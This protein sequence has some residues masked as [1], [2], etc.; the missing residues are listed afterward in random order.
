M[1]MSR[2]C[3]RKRLKFVFDDH[4]D[5]ILLE[6]LAHELH[7]RRSGRRRGRVRARALASLDG[8]VLRS[9]PGLVL[10]RSIVWLI[11][12]LAAL[13][14]W[15]ALAARGPR[16]L[17]SHGKYATTTMRLRIRAGR[18]YEGDVR[19]ARRMSL[20]PV[21][22]G[23]RTFVTCCVWV[24]CL[25]REEGSRRRQQRGNCLQHPAP[26][27][28]KVPTQALEASYLITTTRFHACKKVTDAGNVMPYQNCKCTPRIVC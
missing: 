19:S 1:Q 22:V 2:K 8:S 14:S 13:L 28:S 10:I 17:A 18:D 9:A 24:G 4:P 25:L 15:L 3:L 11:R 6:A 26:H 12:C 23:G 21:K 20:L 27:A 7:R 16:E 5:V